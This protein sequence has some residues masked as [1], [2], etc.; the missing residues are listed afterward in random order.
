[1][2]TSSPSLKQQCL[3]EF[4]GT[5]LFL[6]IGI[7]C[8]AANRLAGASFGM[9]EICIVW[10]LS[11]SLGVYMTAGI[12]GGHIN[13]AVSIAL[14]LF[15]NFEGRKVLP[16]ILS[17]TLGA[18]GGALVA[19]LLYYNLFI[20][21][22]L[23]HHIQRGSMESLA[24]AG[25]FSTFPNP[26]INMVQAFA[27]EM[28]GTLTLMCLIMALTDD[29]NGVP[30]GPLAPL[31]IGITVALIGVAQ[32]MLTGFALNPARDFGPRLFSILAG[33]GTNALTGGREV[34]YFIIPLV[35]PIVGA[36]LGAVLYRSLVNMPLPGK[37]KEKKHLPEQAS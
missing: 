17:Q 28:I 12:S 26:A 6:F 16:Y 37:A 7:S 36:C 30:R 20:D 9:W 34:P 3:A 8:L 5:G 29:G 15:G 18:F 32:G 2:N 25:I 4:L 21:F 24:Q 33:W 31:L 11:V 14:W 1:M 23:A 13:P 27:S 22:E 35:A 19:Y 10:G